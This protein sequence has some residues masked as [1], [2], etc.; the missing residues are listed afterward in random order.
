MDDAHD[1]LRLAEDVHVVNK[2]LKTSRK[3]KEINSEDCDPLS[4]YL[5]QISQYQL[6]TPQNEIDLGKR[7]Q[8]SDRKSVV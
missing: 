4:V 5:K 6:L 8:N 7:I 1:E 2:P 3:C